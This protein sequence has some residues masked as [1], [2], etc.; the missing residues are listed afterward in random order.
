MRQRAELIATRNLQLLTAREELEASRQEIESLRAERDAR[1]SV[2][3]GESGPARG[4]ARA[5]SELT[6]LRM[7]AEQM[8][9]SIEQQA[10]I[11]GKPASAASSSSTGIRA[12]QKKPLQSKPTND[13]AARQWERQEIRKSKLFSSIWYVSHYP[14]VLAAGCDPFEHF[15]EHG[16]SEGRD[17]HPLFDV[18]WYG[19]RNPQVAVSNINALAHYAAIGAAEGVA[20]HPLFDTEF[21]LQNN[22]DLADLAVNPLHQ[23]MTKGGFEGRDPHPLFDSSWYLRQNPDVAAAQE[24]PLVHYNTHGWK[25]GRNP[26]PLFD[27]FFYL[28]QNPDV[29][30][31]DYNP[32]RHFVEY[33]GVEGRDPH[34]QF[35]SAWYREQNPDVAASEMNPLVHYLT[36][37]WR[38]GKNP[39]PSFNAAKVLK[40]G[41]DLSRLPHSPLLTVLLEEEDKSAPSTSVVAAISIDELS[42]A[43]IAADKLHTSL[44]SMLSMFHNGKGATILQRCYQILIRFSEVEFSAREAFATPEVAALIAAIKSLSAQIDGASR[45]K[46]SVII[47]AHNK[48]IYTLCCV[49]SILSFTELGDF[50]IIIADDASSDGTKEVCETIGSAVRVI[51]SE[52]N[53]GFLLNCNS[54]AS[55]ARGEYLILLNNDTFVLPGWLDELVQ[56]LQ[57]NPSIGLCGSKLV[58]ADGTL[59]EAGGIVWKDGSAW[60]FG[61]DDDA[62]APQ[63]NYLK[64]V[65]YI[66][67]AAI[68]LPKRVWESLGGFDEIYCPAYYEDTD[69]AF[70]VRQAGLRTVYQPYSAVIHHEGVSHGRDVTTSIKANQEKNRHIFLDR[71]SAVLEAEHFDNGTHVPLARDRSSKKT[72]IFVVDHYIPQP[73][74]DAGSRSMIH[75]INLFVRSGFQVTFWP[76][77]RHFDPPYAK[78]LQKLGVETIYGSS[79]VWPEFRNWIEA[80]GE[81]L[82]YAFLSRAQVAIDFIDQLRERTTAKILFYGHDIHFRRLQ[83]QLE[84]TGDESI[85]EQIKQWEAIERNIWTLCDTIFYP[86]V[87]EVKYLETQ[88]PSAN[89]RTLPLNIFDDERLVLVERRIREGTIS[90]GNQLLFVGGFRHQPNVDGIKWFMSGAWPIIKAAVPDAT[91]V[92]A[93]S[94]PTVEVRKFADHSVTVTG[95][96]S[97]EELRRLYATTQVA[98][99]PLRFGGGMKGKILEAISF[100]VP[101]VTTSVGIQGLTDSDFAL[102]ADDS[103]TFASKVIFALL[104]KGGNE[105]RDRCLRGLALLQ[106]QFSEA[107]ARRALGIYSSQ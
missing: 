12:I 55:R 82:D 33:G 32:L 85:N 31:S 8:R 56:T 29:R 23:Y 11:I 40:T 58:N 81:F 9:R 50:E 104:D 80:N 98:I 72:R 74:R 44:E 39:N 36:T 38:A 15:L 68:G 26:H 92:I 67:G 22:P 100:G 75:Y 94:S 49:Y 57:E 89:I 86:S 7:Q 76:H 53:L 6:A 13:P 51:T 73:D 78:A 43:P 46:A 70:R 42:A 107:A 83:Q 102:V 103:E 95:E 60:N 79:D 99:V 59:Q 93:G 4:M 64:D 47:P 62:C 28:E 17:P 91:L 2:Q 25:E 61:R 105:S 30:E 65:D 54:A 45:V 106:D 52:M 14:D 10:F 87:E 27:T 101:L 5:R 69:L 77:N 37:G 90:S 88:L 16:A 96:V 21:Y 20:P 48:L 66:S 34:P 41:Y 71:W 97:D 3:E 84:V 35:A 19:A 18:R 1:G 24:N 63:Y